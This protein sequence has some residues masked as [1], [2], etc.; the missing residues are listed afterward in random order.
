MLPPRLTQHISPH[1]LAG[2]GHGTHCAGTVVS[3]KYG[4]AKKADVV[5][6]KVL[7]DSGSGSMS[8]VT[9]GVLWAVE[10]AK[11]QSAAM[12]AN[13]SSTKAKKHK[14]FVANMSLGGGK[15]PTLDRAVDGATKSG[16]AFAVAAGNEN[17]DACNTSPAGAPGPVT[18]GASTINDERAYFSN[19]GKCVDVFGPGL[20]ILS[21]WNTGNTSTNTISGTSMAS[22]HVCGILAYYLSEQDVKSVAPTFASQTANSLFRFLPLQESLAV[23]AYKATQWIFGGAVAEEA[24]NVYAAGLPILTAMSPDSLKTLIEKVATKGALHDL[25]STTVNLLVFNNA[26]LA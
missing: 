17:Q 22:P 25:D 12:T 6:V 26:T 23:A 20:N 4:V 14:G 2:N 11:K 19:K 13:P 8:D 1:P 15:S 7:S 10:D 3:R 16:L 9:G 21:T 18:V 5:A 24:K